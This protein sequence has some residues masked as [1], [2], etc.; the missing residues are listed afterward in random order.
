MQYDDHHHDPGTEGDSTGYRPVSGLAVAAAVTGALSAASLFGTAF[1][2]LPIVAVA[3]SAAALA[4][5]GR[6]GSVKA[7]RGLALIG[8]ALATG[9]GSQAV[10]QRLVGDGIVAMR[11]RAA[12]VEFVRAI[13]EG[14][15]SDARS[16]CRSPREPPPLVGSS[17]EE[18]FA[19]QPAVA[20]LSN[21]G[22]DGAAVMLRQ[23]V[24][25]EHPGE[26]P[27]RAVVPCV[28]R[29]GSGEESRVVEVVVERIEPSADG[30]SLDRWRVVRH[31]VV[32]GGGG[33]GK[34]P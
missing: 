9:F 22:S 10:C 20:A 19:A 5:I 26:F 8:L 13:R 34:I 11:G 25:S 32:A 2:V 21:C 27:F 14:R 12:A 15:L 24:D 17:E 23:P 31:G 1:W 28:S 7:G 18:A 6:P 4:E 33:T 30:G 3:V 29:D 16:M